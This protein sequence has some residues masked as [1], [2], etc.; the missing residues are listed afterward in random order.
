MTDAVP[1]D[2]DVNVGAGDSRLDLGALN[3]STLTV[4]NGAGDARIDLAG[5]HGGR[6]D[7]NIEN[8]VG[9]LTLRL[10]KDSSTRIEVQNG[11]G[12]IEDSG[13]IR[14]NGSFTTTGTA[15]PAR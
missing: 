2:L 11:V 7:A 12:D 6:F 13:L 5:Y 4:K 8:G 14:E 15:R 10:P 1:L 9:D 3:L